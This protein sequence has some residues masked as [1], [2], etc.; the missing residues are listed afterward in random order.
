MNYPHIYHAPSSV[1][2]QA[3]GQPN[4]AL[5]LATQA[6]KTG[7]F[8]RTNQVVSNDWSKLSEV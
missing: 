5:W 1:I 3:E 7:K 8:G 2:G 6:G 4:P